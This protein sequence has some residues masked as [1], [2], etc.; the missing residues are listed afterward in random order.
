MRQRTL[1]AAPAAPG[2]AVGPARGLFA[3]SVAAKVLPAEQREA[4]LEIARGALD[5]ARGELEALAERLR[6]AGRPDEA[7]IVDTGALMAQDPA[8]A[9]S[10]TTR[11]RDD[12]L[13]AP[14]ALVRAAEDHA[15]A[16]AALED[17]T[18]AARAE[19]VR[20]LGRRA[21]RLAAGEGP[22]GWADS[23][24]VV[25]ADDL[26]PADVAEL[27]EHAVAVVLA[28][29]GT[30][31]HAAIV[32]RSLGIPMVVGA[33]PQLA[34]VPEGAT[35]VVDADTG[36]VLVDPPAEARKPA[37]AA[38][39]PRPAAR[40]RAAD[41]RDLPSV[42]RDGQ[43]IALRANAASAAEVRAALEAGAEG[44]GLV[45]TELAFLDVV[46]WPDEAAH[47]RAL[48]PILAPL[49]GQVAT[50]RTLDFGGDK[51]P[52]FLAGR[53]QRA[54]ALQ[55]EDPAALGAQLRAIIAAGR[56]TELRVLLPM[57]EGPV[58]LLTARAALLEA[59]EA[60]P[61]AAWPMLG[62][63]VET[64]RAAAVAHK[65]ALRADFLS[66]GTNDLAASTL[67]ADRFAGADAVAHHPRVLA[68]VART[69]LAASEAGAFVEVCGEA[70]SDPIG[71]PLLVGL[72]VSE[73]SVAPARVGAVR[74]WIR[75]LDAEE[76]AA[77]A[78]R[79]LAAADT[80]E[81]DRLVRPLA[82]RAGLLDEAR[83]EGR[84]L[85]ERNGRV[86]AVRPEA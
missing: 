60:T 58:P 67:G 6:E 47:R 41:E 64:P 77:V 55:L 1:P 45:R 34:E 42:T 12:G 61:G 24:A 15:A 51:T 73:L 39:A 70:A 78:R 20:S 75:A 48:D 7:A 83:D 38:R 65:L 46:D 71:V 54:L 69:V 59:I 11:I 76:T 16:L 52:P 81:V 40:R 53:R 43:A 35:V 50:V 56:D 13:D 80:E 23:G 44:V 32:A 82:E 3:G 31:A 68:L 4:E 33:G 26:G 49:A 29:G 85:V 72:G 9:E 28:R 37:V 2:Q 19:D 27:A 74:R 86:A 22:E 5:A 14:A 17:P 57:V 79:A 18:L 66:I 36:V 30:T 10:V 84:E 25:L 8:L 62:A 21:A 63:M